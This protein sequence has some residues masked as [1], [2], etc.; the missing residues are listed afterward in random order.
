M[1]RIALMTIETFTCALQITILIAISVSNW[2]IFR[3][4]RAM[5]EVL[6]VVLRYRHEIV[7][8]E[9]RISLLEQ[10]RVGPLQ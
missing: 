8:L 1:D 3:S 2:R 7:W 6:E 10:Q 5:G 4:N 9:E